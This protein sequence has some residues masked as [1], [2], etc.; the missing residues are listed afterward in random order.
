MWNIV[1][2]GGTRALTSLFV[3]SHLRMRN[4]VFAVEHYAEQGRETNQIESGFNF[5]VLRHTV[6]I[7]GSFR[8][9]FSYF[10]RFW[11]E[12]S[13]FPPSPPQEYVWDGG[14]VGPLKFY[15]H[16][17]QREETSER[18]GRAESAERFLTGKH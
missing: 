11:V 7:G 18:R 16:A 8:Q 10:M 13:N 4:E 5:S 2:H 9:L 1:E 12:I 17:S 14:A 3:P 6:R 15:Y